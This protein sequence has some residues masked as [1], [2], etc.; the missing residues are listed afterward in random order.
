MKLDKLKLLESIIEIDL[1]KENVLHAFFYR[2]N[3]NW[4]ALSDGSMACPNQ[5]DCLDNS[6]REAI[7]YYDK[8]TCTAWFYIEEYEAALALTFAKPTRS[9][10]RA[11]LRE[12]LSSILSRADNAY[13]VSHHPLTHLLA[14]DAFRDRLL[15]EILAIKDQLPPSIDAQESEEPT[16][17]ALLALDIDYFKQVNDTWGHLYG[18]QVLKVFGRRLE[19]AAKKIY[20]GSES[21]PQI[22]IGHPSGE[23]FLILITA[24]A[25][26]NEFS[27]WANEF[28]LSI[29]EE[30]LPTDTE[31]AWLSTS[32]DLS[33][34]SPPPT[35][36]R[37]VTTSIGIAF[38]TSLTQI[39]Q[40]TK[41][42]NGSSNLLD[43]AD[44]ALYRA[45][46]AGRNQVI[47]YDDILSSCGRILEHDQS[48]GVIAI[49]IGKN[50]GVTNGQEFRAFH[51]TYSGNEKF[52][53][54]DGR[55][56][57]TLGTYPRVESARII[58]F[59][60][61]PEISFAY[62]DDNQDP[63]LKLPVSSTLEAIPAGS[64]GHLLPSSSKFSP[65]STGS[66]PGSGIQNLQKNI[67][68]SASN[69]QHPF[70]IV[71]RF[72]R[73]PEYSKKF[74]SASLNSALARLYK[75]AQMS[76]HSSRAVEVLD[77]GS[78]CIVGNGNSYSEKV[79]TDFATQIAHSLPELGI[80]VGV[81]N[82]EDLIKLNKQKIESVVPSSHIELARLSA[83][84]A[85][86]DPASRIRH[87]STDTAQTILQSL[88]RDKLFET[89]YTD[90][91]QLLSFGISTANIL[92]IGGLTAGVLGFNI[93][94]QKLFKMAIV[95]S[96]KTLIFKTN[97][98]IASYNIGD[99]DSGLDTLSSITLKNINTIQS[100][101]EY[102][103]FV[104]T[105]LLASAKMAGSARF[106]EERFSLMAPHA[107]KMNFKS[108]RSLKAI[109]TIKKAMEG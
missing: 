108:S 33:A 75:A 7:S 58:V 32:E 99:F 29:S 23:E 15:S 26:K 37:S 98:G 82:N 71:V 10:T 94:A 11:R 36:D 88:R 19:D 86:L 79:L 13:R 56:T 76:F 45:K 61:Q 6:S 14:K 55:T 69:N 95:K 18:D 21:R 100:T 77:K 89:A 106:D 12:M 67:E 80:L 47:F 90:F 74:G 41:P 59:N 109:Y 17:L 2:N 105:S 52:L 5:T 87:F 50:V 1:L 104:Y 49:D 102:G 107:I 46:A 24:N 20:K 65:I 84:G 96:P 22:F 51:P 60:S 93:E 62:I 16:M 34:I 92:N 42:D 44:T 103:Y 64:I 48:T 63:L 72:N 8:H 97:Y 73:E 3:T 25:S 85:G 27:A 53:I 4:M 91:Q 70:A 83:S 9:P 30:V 39:K 43:L 81:F 38:H 35:R 28:R 66:L 101:H 31:W 40:P 68:E 78:I 54:N 57:R